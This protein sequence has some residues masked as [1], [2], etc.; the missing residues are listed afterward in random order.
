MAL[1]AGGALAAAM[2]V[3]QQSSENKVAHA[4]DGKNE[5]LIPFAEKLGEGEMKVLKVGDGDD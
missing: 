5:V 2:L 3:N 4:G 1:A